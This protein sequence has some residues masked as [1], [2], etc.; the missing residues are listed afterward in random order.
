MHDG[1][2]LGQGAATP[3]RRA[4]RADTRAHPHLDRL[5]HQAGRHQRQSLNRQI[6]ALTEAGCIRIFAD[7]NSGKNAEREELRKARDYLREGDTLVVPSL[8]RLGRSIQGTPF[9]PG[10]TPCWADRVNA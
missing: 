7:Q 2:P 3:I 8:D 4:P 5:H 6:H 9:P 10:G 1:P